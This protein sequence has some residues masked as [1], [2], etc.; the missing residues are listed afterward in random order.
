MTTH[1]T[2]II[3]EIALESMSLAYHWPADFDSWLRSQLTRPSCVGL[4]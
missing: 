2:R 3:P 1:H 4:E